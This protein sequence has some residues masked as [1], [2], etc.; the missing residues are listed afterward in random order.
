MLVAPSQEN[1][2]AEDFTVPLYVTGS[3]EPLEV[4]SGVRT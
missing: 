4:G 3:V 2:A 1:N